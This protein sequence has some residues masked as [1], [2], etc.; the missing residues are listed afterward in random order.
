MGE[1]KKFPNNVCGPHKPFKPNQ[2]TTYETGDSP[3]ATLS[4]WG[5]AS[6]RKQ[7]ECGR[8]GLSNILNYIYKQVLFI[9][10]EQVKLI[11]FIWEGVDF[12]LGIRYVPLRPN[13]IQPNPKPRSMRSCSE[14][15]VFTCVHVLSYVFT[16]PAFMFG[17]C[18]MAATVVRYIPASSDPRLDA[19]YVAYVW[20]VADDLGG[21]L[22][23]PSLTSLASWPG[24]WRALTLAS[25]AALQLASTISG[26]S[27]ATSQRLSVRGCQ[28][29]AAGWGRTS[30]QLRWTVWLGIVRGPLS[31]STGPSL[32]A[33]IT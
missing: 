25:A 31:V 29:E 12:T 16:F 14:L 32:F 26:Q 18:E 4:Y 1:I 6:S 7:S 9:T 22:S 28:S 13:K 23:W 19:V 10:N 30:N 33:F 3:V 21:H 20:P 5:Q 15:Y 8:H 24:R 11:S 27:E 2:L 17:S